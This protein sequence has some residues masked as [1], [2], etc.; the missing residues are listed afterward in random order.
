MNSKKNPTQ[1][2]KD[3][4]RKIRAVDDLEISKFNQ[5]ARD[6]MQLLGFCTCKVSFQSY[7]DSSV[8]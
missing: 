4:G 8:G 2:A 6:L 3:E 1:E 7:F 5:E